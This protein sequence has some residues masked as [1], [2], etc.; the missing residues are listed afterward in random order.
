M[1]NSPITSDGYRA[2]IQDVKQRIQSAQIKAAVAVNQT[3]LCLY[4]DIAA[5]IVA[6]QQEAA[7]GDGFLVQ[8]SR[9]LQ[10]AF[11]DMKGFS[12]RNLE[13][14]RQWYRFWVREP[15]IAQQLV[16]QIPAEIIP[17][18]HRGNRG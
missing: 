12:K 5:S 4:W 7:W 11:P 18:Q 8:M 2:F 9:D 1:S 6:K 15:A 14:M 13:V 16:A 3:L 10:E 17:A